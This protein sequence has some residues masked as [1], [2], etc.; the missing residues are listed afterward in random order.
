M[1]TRII[2]IRTADL[3]LKAELNE[4]PTADEIY[5]N[6]PFEGS[7]NVWGDEIYFT[8]PIHVE[9]AADAIEEVEVG[10]LAFWPVGD[11]FCIFFGRTPVST[12]EMPRAYSPVNVFGRITGDPTVL[13]SVSNGDI[14][15]VIKAE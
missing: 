1:E 13:R 8:I 4:T 10:A 6:L 12:G 11:A 2:N 15:Q 5:S 7:A 9:Q 3:E 14:V